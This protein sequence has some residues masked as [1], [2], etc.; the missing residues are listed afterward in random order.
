VT[1]LTARF[2]ALIAIV[3]GL[4]LL[5]AGV[6][7]DRDSRRMAERSLEEEGRRE[8]ALLRLS[9]PAADISAGN[10]ARV[11]A[12]CDRAGAAIGRRVTAIDSAGRVLGD[13]EVPLDSVPL[14]ENHAGRPEIRAALEKGLGEANR[15][16]WTIRRKLFYIAEP[17]APLDGV[18]AGPRAVLRIS[19]PIPQAYETARRW[20]THLWI[21]VAAVFLAVLAGG[22]V[23]GRRID[24]RLRAMRRSAES[25]GEGDL[26]TRMPVDAH[27]E[28]G[29][30]A[31]VLN[32]MAGRLDSKISEL[33][34]ERNLSQAVIGN[35][36]EGVALLAPDLTIL[37]AN[38]LFWQLVGAERPGSNPRLAA[39]RQPVLEEVVREAMR[40]GT[41]IRREATLYVEDRREHEIA[42]AP[43]REG[44]ESGDWLL[45]IR[46][47]KPERAMAN[48]RREF[49]ANVSHELKTPLTS[50]RGYAETLLQGGLEDEANR[51]RFV[52]T[53][54][55]QAVRLEALVEDL[56]ELADLDRPD[57][58]LDLKD[59]D[60][61]TVVR[62][63]AAGF[64]E[65][66]ARRGLALDLEVRPGLRANIDR[67]RIEVALRNLL[68][69]AIKYT[70]S[71]R[72]RIFAE[73]GPST[74]R[75]SVADT[76][77]GIEPQHLP[78]VFERFY[79]ADLGRSRAMGGTGL[80]LSIV[81]H[82]V[83]LHG[84]T[85]GVESA[86]NRGSTFWFE[87]TVSGPPGV[88]PPGAPS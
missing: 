84:G 28:L 30:L 57:A 31:R 82:A 74:V 11:D 44:A 69:N 71:G 76:G 12:W 53:I 68:D 20:Q 79:R 41:A 87:I 21:A 33:Q 88:T 5:I 19:M 47:L 67:K 8:L 64:E 13:S 24:R 50:I 49:V 51:S 61:A 45:T 1:S 59:W 52:E 80:G 16:S 48:L 78:R 6:S 46:D 58:A 81:K 3:L 15:R 60:L 23:L 9:A 56:L 66:A 43:V 62:D 63:L 7:L 22:F 83:E 27:D 35:L 72:V 26:A 54:R 73:R 29:A 38:D 85:V 17:L 14:M 37:H 75:I 36:S 10:I 42:V 65:L 32:S 55:T 40:H 25:L 18:R 34:A 77:R 86:H 70:D 2:Y 39:A 4:G